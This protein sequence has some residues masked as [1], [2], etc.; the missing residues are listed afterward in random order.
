MKK[1]MILT[2]VAAMAVGAEA[3]TTYVG[4]NLSD[5]NTSGQT[6]FGLWRTAGADKTALV[7]QITALRETIAGGEYANFSEVSTYILDE[8]KPWT[9]SGYLESQ[10]LSG[11]DVGYYGAKSGGADYGNWFVALVAAESADGKSVELR[12]YLVGPRSGVS[13]DEQI[14]VEKAIAGAKNNGVVAVSATSTLAYTVP[15]PTSGLLMLLGVAGL[16]LKRK[17]A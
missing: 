16:A 11:S 2:A 6:Y 9:R 1:L 14:W 17:R 3:A 7:D 15:E 13:N 10:P 12:Q 8:G 5:L 4:W